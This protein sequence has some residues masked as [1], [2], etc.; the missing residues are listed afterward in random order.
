MLA[1]F[2]YADLAEVIACTRPALAKHGLAV[3][4]PL[5]GFG[6]GMAVQTWLLHEGGGALAEGLAL[7]LDAFALGDNVGRL[8]Q[9]AHDAHVTRVHHHLEGA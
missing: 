2:A 9:G 3:V 7:G 5:V 6:D 4:Q 8:G 1:R